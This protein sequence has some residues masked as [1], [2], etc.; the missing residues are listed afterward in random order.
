MPA[1]VTQLLH[2]TE[3][4]NGLRSANYGAGGLNQYTNRAVPGAYDIVGA[5]TATSAVTVNSQSPY[6]KGEY[7]WKEITA[8]NGS[9]P[10]W[11]TNTVT[12]SGGAT[13]GGNMLVPPA[14]QTFGHDLDG[15]L[16]NDLVWAYLWDGENRLIQMS[17]VT[18]V[19]S[20]AR[21]KLDFNYDHQGRRFRKVMSTWNGSA[22]V[23]AQTNGFHYYGWNVLGDFVSASNFRHYLWGS[24][25]SG[26]LQGAGGVGG[27]IA[28]R[29]TNQVHFVAYD[30]NGNVAGL[31]NS[32][33]GA[34]SANYEYGPFGE[35]IRASGTFAKNN[36]YRFSTKYQDAESDLLYYGYRFLNTSTGKWM[37]RD[38]I[39]ESGGENLFGFV[40]NTPTGSIDMLGLVERTARYVGKSFIN[41]IGPLGS[42]G[43]R[44]G[45]A[46]MPLILLGVPELSP[47]PQHADQR[48]AALA[49]LVGGL[50][51]FNQNPLTDVKDGQYRLYGKVEITANC[52]AGFLTS[53]SYKTDM[54]GGTELPKFDIAG[55]INM[56]VNA[57]RDGLGF[58]PR[59]ATVTWKTWGRPNLLVEPGMQWVALRTSVNIWHEGKVRISCNGSKPI[60]TAM[61]FRGSRYPSRRLWQDGGKPIV[62]RPQGPLSS[63][64]DA[65]SL[66]EPTMVHE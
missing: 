54:E 56:E 6:R 26:S 48:L 13:N 10:V 11:Q 40:K 1:E 47:A 43:N 4:G 46:P 28:V 37:S 42:L 27:L 59:S 24:D 44:W 51:A 29:E 3:S 58:S 19:A 20:A 35:S 50:A 65:Q 49:S 34:V 45:L 12:V 57:R 32:A 22:W 15:N 66:W 61:G 14:T 5:A 25:L 23:T 52:C 38:L 55:T 16:T 53:Y 21:R 39:E 60:F 30:G 64:W 18:S 8:S 33:D 7:F 9:G 41:G 36:P 31:V 62:D 63:L 17:N 2:A